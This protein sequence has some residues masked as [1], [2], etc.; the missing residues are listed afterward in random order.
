MSAARWS[1]YFTLPMIVI[2][3]ILG[4]PLLHLWIGPGYA[5]DCAIVLTVLA[6]GRMSSIIQEALRSV[7]TGL[8]AHGRPGLATLAASICVV[9]LAIVAVGPLQAALIG[10]ALAISIPMTLADGIFVPI[11]TRRPFA[12]SPWRFYRK[13]L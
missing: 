7:L 2:L 4:G 3:A 9:I 13:T 1:A 6:L 5:R 11:F 8:N 12:I 10:A